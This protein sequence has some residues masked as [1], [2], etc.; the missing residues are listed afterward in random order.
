VK[1]PCMSR[2]KCPQHMAMAGGLVRSVKG[3]EGYLC[4]DEGG[5]S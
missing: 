3:R 2:E 4:G 1:W 5:R